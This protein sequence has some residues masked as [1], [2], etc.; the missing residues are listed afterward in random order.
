MEYTRLGNSGL[1]VSK[2]CLGCM[3]FG[4]ASKWSRGSWILNEEESMKIIKRALEL[5]INFFDTADMYSLGESERILGKAIK[6][7]ANRDDVVIATKIFYPLRDG[8]NNKGLSRKYI[9]EAVEA[10]LKRL[11]MDYIDLLVI[12]RFDYDT[13][14]EET[15]EALH[16]LIKMGKIRYIGASAMYAWQF[17]KANYIAE[18]NGWTKFISMQNHYNLLYREDERELIPYCIDSGIQLTPYSPL[19]SGRLSRSSHEQSKRFEED[20]VTQDKYINTL[21]EDNRIIDRVGKIADRKGITRVQVALAWLLSH[22]YVASPLI[23]ATKIS[24]LEGAISALDVK[25]TQEEI[26][27]LEE[28]TI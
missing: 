13:P 10:S 18:K 19:A 20:K 25:L 17:Q 15:M 5:G 26:N 6:K 7:Y 11:D 22:N 3:G 1:E 4:D 14:L 12:H 9:F 8:K 23:G 2:L 28:L 27:Y 24:H 16:D 21:K